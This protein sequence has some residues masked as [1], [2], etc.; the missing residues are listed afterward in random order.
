[1]YMFQLLWILFLSFAH[2]CPFASKYEADA[3]DWERANLTQ[4]HAAFT[5][6]GAAAIRQKLNLH[7]THGL[8]RMPDARPSHE[9]RRLHAGRADTH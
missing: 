7:L 9:L 3:A 8:L 6:T 5:A 2:A 4:P 1:M